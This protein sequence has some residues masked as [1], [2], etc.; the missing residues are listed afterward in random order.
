MNLARRLVAEGLG[1]GLL[2][3]TVVGSGIMGASLLFGWL[4]APTGGVAESS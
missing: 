3:A 1:I 2:L 4:L